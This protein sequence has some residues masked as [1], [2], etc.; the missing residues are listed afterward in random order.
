MASKER[1][2]QTK[3]SDKEVNSFLKKI[4]ETRGAM[5]RNKRGRLIFAMDATASREPTWS[6]ACQIQTEMFSQTATLGGLDVQLC[7]YRG[8]LEFHYSDWISESSELLAKMRLVRCA[9]GATQ[10]A[11]VLE[12]TIQEK[13]NGGVATL[14]FVGDCLEEDM[15]R[16][17][18]LAGTMGLL[19]IPAFVFQEG[20]D[21]IAEKAFR[22]I[23]RLSKGIFNRFDANSPRQLRELLGAA[24]VYAAG[25]KRALEHYAKRE[26][27]MV[28][29]LLTRF[30]SGS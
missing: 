2:L 14:V 16:L 4:E 26:G 6:Q 23:A 25:G 7:Y 30:G 13:N 28:Q 24:A 29:S 17:C 22:E 11:R 19:G 10:I 5:Q 12:H 15:D 27:A 18:Q 9:G 21:P 1:N 8:F 20:Y 3:S